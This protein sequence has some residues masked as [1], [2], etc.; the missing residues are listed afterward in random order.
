LLETLWGGGCNTLIIAH[1]EFSGEFTASSPGAI[2]K[3]HASHY[4]KGLH[5]V[6]CHIIGAQRGVGYERSLLAPG[7]SCVIAVEHTSKQQI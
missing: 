7:R 1:E 4:M 2:K 5:E 3:F 6:V